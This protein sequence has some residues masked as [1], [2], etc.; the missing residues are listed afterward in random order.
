MNFNPK[1]IS[2]STGQSNSGRKRKS[3][4]SQMLQI[5]TKLKRRNLS[6]QCNTKATKA[7]YDPM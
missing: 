5:K 6:V 1:I 3:I 4:S 2:N 7:A